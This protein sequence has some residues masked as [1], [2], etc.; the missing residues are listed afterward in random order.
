MLRIAG[1]D[2]DHEDLSHASSL[3]SC[4]RPCCGRMPYATLCADMKPIRRNLDRSLALWLMTVILAIAGFAMSSP[5]SAHTEHGHGTGAQVERVQV[6]RVQ[7]QNARETKAVQG[8]TSDSRMRAVVSVLR[9][10]PHLG[11]AGPCCAGGCGA[12]CCALGLAPTEGD[13]ASSAGLTG[14]V[15]VGAASA[16]TDA[17]PDSPSEPPRSFA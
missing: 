11:C 12:P 8:I 17:A 6:E 16:R 3:P 15:P 5:A 13:V 14:P 9:A 10:E 7:V 4:D 1:A 2:A